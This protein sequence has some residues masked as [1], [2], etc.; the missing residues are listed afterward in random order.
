[1]EGQNDP[2]RHVP[3]TLP[4]NCW[5]EMIRVKLLQLMKME[6]TSW[7]GAGHH[8]GLFWALSHSLCQPGL[9]TDIRL[10]ILKKEL[11]AEKQARRC[12]GKSHCSCFVFDRMRTKIRREKK[13]ERKFPQIY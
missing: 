10:E 3:H 11:G 1:M 9:E 13:G 2:L 7:L 6:M 5:P 8:G 12:T 4:G